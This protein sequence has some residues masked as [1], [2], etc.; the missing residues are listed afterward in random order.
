MAVQMLFLSTEVCRLVSVRVTGLD[1]LSGFVDCLRLLPLRINILILGLN[2]TLTY[3]SSTAFSS[4]LI[5]PRTELL[6]SSWIFPSSPDYLLLYQTFLLKHSWISFIPMVVQHLQRVYWN[7][8][9]I[10]QPS[11]WYYP[12]PRLMVTL[13]LHVNESSRFSA[14]LI[15]YFFRIHLKTAF[16]IRTEVTATP[17]YIPHPQTQWTVI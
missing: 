5:W 6:I 14:N 3:P 9:L 13:M 10:W 1:I 8:S 11:A 7:L 12:L 2:T 15:F 16:W 17:K 4:A